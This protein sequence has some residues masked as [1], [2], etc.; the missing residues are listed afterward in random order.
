M[1]GGLTKANPHQWRA[2][3]KIELNLKIKDNIG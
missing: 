1:K 3:L 2:Q